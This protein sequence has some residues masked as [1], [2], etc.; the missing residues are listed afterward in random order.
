MKVYIPL[1]IDN[2]EETLKTVCE[3]ALA[4]KY[5]ESI[6][7]QIRARYESELGHIVSNGFSPYYILAS[8]LA[9]RSRELGYLHNLRGSAGG[10]FIVYLMGISETNPLPPHFYCQE[11]RRVEF[12]DAEE[13][14][15]GFDLNRHDR[16]RKHCPSCGATL[17][18]D[19]HNIPVEFFSGFYGDKTPD[20]DLNIAPEIQNEI[21]RYPG[22]IFGEDNVLYEGTEDMLSC[23]ILPHTM[24]TKLKR[25]EEATGVSARSIKLEDIDMFS[26][27][28]DDDFKGL[29]F[30][31]EL[32]RRISD[33]VF[34]SRFSD[35]VK[36]L[37]FAHGRNVWT[38]NGENLA[39]TVCYPENV[40]AHRDDVM[41]TLIEH[42][43]DRKTA[44][45][46]A[47]MVR[48]GEAES[49]L[50]K[51][52]EG[53]LLNHGIPAWYIDSMKKVKYLFPKAHST[54]YAMNYL[55]M[56]WYKIN[57]PEAFYS[58]ISNFDG[59][60]KLGL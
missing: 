10:S 45:D 42:G 11:C 43:I 58:A 38:D 26:F 29:P 9:T 33:A 50:T 60:N 59:L 25:M 7:D 1:P 2:A 18:G 13:Y 39:G 14:H 52:Q 8:M 55:R 5:G 48:K 23:D 49:H 28:M 44:F 46:T 31:G 15:S 47:E 57:T 6:P 21:I 41:L 20:F 34:P 32:V 54:E 51:E 40:I 24:F 19:G 27:F 30:D 3:Q 22:D 35:L 56:I 53:T 12:V 36:V 17:I 37:G 16:E 4:E